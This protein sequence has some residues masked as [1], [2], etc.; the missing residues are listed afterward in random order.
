MSNDSTQHHEEIH[1]PAPSAAPIIVGA[2]MT[3]T[4]TGILSPMLLIL[5]VVLLAIG[6]GMWAFRS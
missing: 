5:G 6:I 1:L 3:L 4:L 2:G